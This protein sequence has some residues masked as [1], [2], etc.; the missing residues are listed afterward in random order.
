M[1]DKVLVNCGYEADKTENATVA[2]IVANAAAAAGKNLLLDR[3]NS[4]KI[5]GDRY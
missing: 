5:Q 4:K 3:K 2:M 1:S